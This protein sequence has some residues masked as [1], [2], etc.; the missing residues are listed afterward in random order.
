MKEY[1][2]TMPIKYLYVKNIKLRYVFKIVQILS[3]LCYEDYVDVDFERFVSDITNIKFLSQFCDIKSLYDYC[4]DE[5]VHND[6]AKR[7]ELD[8]YS[9]ILKCDIGDFLIS[10]DTF[11]F[12][13][14][15]IYPDLLKAHI[16]C[17]QRISFKEY[18]AKLECSFGKKEICS[19]Y[20]DMNF[21]DALKEFKSDFSLYLT[22]NEIGGLILPEEI[23]YY[24]DEFKIKV[25]LGI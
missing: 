1:I 14:K 5:Y 18:V 25:Q 10:L 4:M 8:D 2:V 17:Y 24:Q 13:N 21:K 12:L 16:E 20:G 7:I 15:K 6:A 19:L 11:I 9:T 23:I 22:Y 3:K